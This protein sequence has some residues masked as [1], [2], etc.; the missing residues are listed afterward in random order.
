MKLPWAGPNPGLYAVLTTANTDVVV[1]VPAGAEGVVLWFET[2]ESNPSVIGGRVALS[3][4]NTVITPIVNT[5]AE[6][7]YHPPMPVEYAFPERRGLAGSTALYLHLANATELAVVRG[8]WLF[9][10]NSGS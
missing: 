8:Y 5:D 7:G 3:P 4:S 2:S 1:T 10:N 6:L 9:G